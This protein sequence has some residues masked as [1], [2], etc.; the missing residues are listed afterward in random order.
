MAAS[1]YDDECDG[2]ELDTPHAGRSP[3]FDLW[4]QVFRQ[5][6]LDADGDPERRTS[7]SKPEDVRAARRQIRRFDDDMVVLCTI[8]GLDPTAVRDALH[9]KARERGWW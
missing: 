8:I 3:E 7:S 1:F 4:A 5:L 6:L 2:T 9:R